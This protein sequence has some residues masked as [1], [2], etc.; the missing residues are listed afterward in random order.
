MAF[1]SQEP[2]DGV[3]ESARL[4]PYPPPKPNASNQPIDMLLS[5][6]HYI[7]LYPDRIVIIRSLDDHIVHEEDLDLVCTF[8]YFRVLV[9][10]LLE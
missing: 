8:A 1:S 6:F 2:G 3:I 10:A 9:K 4:V 7:L 5:Q